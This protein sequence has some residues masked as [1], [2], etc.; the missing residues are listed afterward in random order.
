MLLVN[1]FSCVQ[2]GHNIEHV[3]S[4]LLAWTCAWRN[5]CEPEALVTAAI[6]IE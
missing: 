3:V 1:D 4:I 2:D 5:I 6:Y